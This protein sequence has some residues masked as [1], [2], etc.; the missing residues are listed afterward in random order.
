MA[1]TLEYTAPMRISHEIIDLQG[2]RSALR[3]GVRI[4]LL[5]RHSERP[6][7]RPDD[8]EFGKSLRLTP[9]GIEWA[10]AFGNALND[11][12]G[13]QFSASPMTRCQLTAQ[14]IAYGMG[15]L[16][17]IV[18][19]ADALG[20]NGFYYEDPIA[21][22]NCMRQQGFMPYMQTYLQHGV[23][24]YSRPIGPA[25]QQ[26][27]EWLQQQTTTQF[28]IYVSHDIFIASFLTHLKMRSF[29]AEN[30]VGVLHG[31]ALFH[32]NITGWICHSFI[33]NLE[34]YTIPTQ[35]IH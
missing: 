19:D 18:H 2:V 28:G 16:N 34:N 7:I 10:Q 12:Q 8:K 1:E 35:F 5:V 21:V 6:A 3:N 22:Q 30:W 20:V 25:T 4:A 14:H 27:A 11:L 33:P 29:S 17:P 32:T 13:V 15:Y 26:L 31:I 9:R 23:A 24:P